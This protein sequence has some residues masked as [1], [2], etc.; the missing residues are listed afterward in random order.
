MYIYAISDVHGNLNALHET[1]KN[2][3]LSDS[4][5]QLILLGDYI[6]GGSQSCET[7]YFIMDLCN[8]YPKQ[9][10]VLRGNH[11]DMFLEEISLVDQIHKEY[12]VTSIDYREL[13]K[14]LSEND[15]NTIMKKFDNLPANERMFKIYKEIIYLIKSTH[16]ELI[17]FLKMLLYYHETENQIYV[18]AGI[19]EECGEYWKTGCEE[20]Y[21]AW[22]YPADTGYFYRDIV[23]GHI[24]SV[25]ISNDENYLGKVFWDEKNHFF[26]DG[27]TVKSG[28]VPILKYDTELKKYSSYVK[29]DNGKWT[30]YEITK[31]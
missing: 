27:D 3:D 15:L 19:D 22:K 25:E 4:N 10:I 2:I 6:D 8:K 14:Y 9:V 20:D 30:E 11:E 7:L 31:K 26:I 23:A 24:S 12:L 18:H 21:F 28:I 5:N 17:K 16:K 29:C 1:L 13:Q